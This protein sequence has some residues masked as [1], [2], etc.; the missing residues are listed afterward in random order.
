MKDVK[1]SKGFRKGWKLLSEGKQVN[2]RDVKVKA[3]RVSL[4][5]SK[6]KTIKSSA[7]LKRVVV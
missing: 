4:S 1:K 5:I 3:K 2:L 6:N 7:Q